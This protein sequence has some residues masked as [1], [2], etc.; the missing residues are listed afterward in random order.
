MWNPVCDVRH[1]ATPRGP[2]GDRRS[3][4]SI[5]K[6]EQQT[7]VP[8][9]AEPRAPAPS[10]TRSRASRVPLLRA[11]RPRQWSKNVLLAGRAERSRS[12]RARASVGRDVAAR[13]RRLLHAVE[14][15]LPAQRR[16]RSRAGPRASA[17]ARTSDRSRARC[18]SAPRSRSPSRSALGGL[19]LAAAVRLEL[20]AVGCG[21]LALTASYSLW[22]RR[23][24]AARHRSR[25]PAAFVRAR[26]RR[27]RRDATYPSRDGS[28][29]VTSCGADLRG[30]R[31]A[32][33]RA[34]RRRP[35]RALTRIDAA[36][37]TRAP[38]CARCS[39]RGGRRAHRHT[40][41]GRSGGPS[42]DRG[43]R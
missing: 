26:R 39:R 43:T 18:R 19:A 6:P 27:R 35:S 12:D 4:R 9:E 14:R 3:A 23:V 40:R 25:S 36:R 38:P 15:H 8:R 34:V 41:Y 32:P 10:A 30:R 21:Y 7:R 5:L 29:L 1:R 37:A 28:S 31:Q 2:D 16:A 33:R 11:C 24:I 42:T 20:A 17:Q 22:L 13:D